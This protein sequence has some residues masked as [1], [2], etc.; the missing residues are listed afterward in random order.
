MP[1]TFD[2]L[3]LWR[4]FPKSKRDK[5]NAQVETIN[6]LTQGINPP[7]QGIT[8]PIPLGTSN[9]LTI[10]QFSVVSVQTDYIQCAALDG[11]S[12][13]GD[14]KIAMPY[15]LRKTPFDG[16]TRNS[17]DYTYSSNIKRTATKGSDVETQVIVPSYVVGDTIY[18]AFNV[19]GFLDV[20]FTINGVET[21]IEWLDL[22]IDGR[23]WAREAA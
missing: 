13:S 23:A 12:G 1:D 3:E 19:I 9:P 4:G 21:L 22:N 14:Y 7:R 8:N 16:K 5:M 6:R 15:L 18:A 17:I 2:R 10:K 20:I 11:F